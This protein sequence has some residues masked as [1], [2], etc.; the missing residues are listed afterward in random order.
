LNF[1]LWESIVKFRSFR[2]RDSKIIYCG[3]WGCAWCRKGVR[4]GR[5]CDG[6]RKGV[7]L[8]RA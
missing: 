1:L 7:R 4:L 8:G 6:C 3:K 5:G 2:R